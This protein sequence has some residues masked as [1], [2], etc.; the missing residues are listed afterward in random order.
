LLAKEFLMAI[1]RRHQIS[2]EN[3]GSIG[4]KTILAGGT[5]TPLLRDA[6]IELQLAIIF[7]MFFRSRFLGQK[8][9]TT[10]RCG[11]DRQPAGTTN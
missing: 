7:A 3:Q 5:V 6:K 10:P 1:V 2:A 9:R 11:E 8:N 4:P